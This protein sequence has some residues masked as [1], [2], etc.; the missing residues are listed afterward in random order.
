MLEGLLTSRCL[1]KTSWLHDGR[2]INRCSF[3]WLRKRKS[4]LLKVRR[5]TE[6][7]RPLLCR[8]HPDLMMAGISTGP[9]LTA[10][11]STSLSHCNV[12]RPM[13]RPL[14]CRG[15]H[16]GMMTGVSTGPYLTACWSTSLSHRNV[17]RPMHRPLL[18]R[19]HHDGMMTGVSTGP[20]L[21]L[22]RSSSRWVTSVRRLQP[23][24]TCGAVLWNSS[25]SSR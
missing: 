16:D 8:R 18:C 6:A 1:L 12:S 3:R 10:C 21:V 23:P 5:P 4:E 20:C 14:L 25:S 24:S 2:H 13:H 19:G 7:K 9:Y 15:H 11:W 22:C 17:S